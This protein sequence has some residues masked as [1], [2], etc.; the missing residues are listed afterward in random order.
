MAASTPTAPTLFSMDKVNK[1]ASLENDETKWLRKCLPIFVQPQVDLDNENHLIKILYLFLRN[2]DDGTLSCHL[3][4]IFAG[5]SSYNRINEHKHN[6]FATLM[7]RSFNRHAYERTADI[8]YMEFRGVDLAA[9]STQPWKS[10][11]TEDHGGAQRWSQGD[12][13]NICNWFSLMHHYETEVPIEEWNLVPGGYRPY[14]YLNT[15]NHMIGET[16]NNP[17]MIKHEWINYQFQ[18]GDAHD[19]LAWVKEHIPTKTNLYSICCCCWARNGGGCCDRH[20]IHQ[21]K[22]LHLKPGN[23]STNDVSHYILHEDPQVPAPKAVKKL[24]QKRG[25]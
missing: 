20:V 15:C 25:Y 21:P 13:A 12:K 22:E 7:Y 19:A 3:C 16:D 14:V 23:S 17:S 24:K 8:N 6:S 9:D 1:D 18:E 10:I 11:Y 2:P 5:E 4:V